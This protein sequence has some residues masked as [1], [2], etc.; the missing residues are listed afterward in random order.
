[1]RREDNNHQGN[2]T[3]QL[4]QPGNRRPTQENFLSG[5]DSLVRTLVAAPSDESSTSKGTA[6]R[7]T[8]FSPYGRRRELELANVGANP[9]HTAVDLF[10]LE[11]PALDWI[12]LAGAMGVEAARVDTLQKLADLLAVSNRRSDLF[13]IELVFP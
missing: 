3:A 12:R 10:D 5:A 1:M 2:A 11:N 9:N 6:R 4:E 7:S 8:R 13:L